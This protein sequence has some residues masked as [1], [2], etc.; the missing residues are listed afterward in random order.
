M[1]WRYPMVR[2]NALTRP[3]LRTSSVKAVVTISSQ[4]GTHIKYLINFDLRIV[5]EKKYGLDTTTMKT[6]MLLLIEWKT[7]AD[8]SRPRTNF[9]W[10]IYSFAD[11]AK[12]CLTESLNIKESRP[13][14]LLNPHKMS[15]NTLSVNPTGISKA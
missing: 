15:S 13:T 6:T 12:K 10:R 3:P 7:I 8:L 1:K 2:W 9:I 14:K 4:S 11:L 5:A